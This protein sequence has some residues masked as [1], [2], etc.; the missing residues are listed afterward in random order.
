MAS[1]W[2]PEEE[3]I[4]GKHRLIEVE[5]LFPADLNNYL[6][7]ILSR[8]EHRARAAH[9]L[10][11]NLKFGFKSVPAAN[12][13]FL[14]LR[15]F[16][17]LEVADLE[18]IKCYI[19]TIINVLVQLGGVHE[20]PK[21]VQTTVNCLDSNAEN[22]VTCGIGGVGKSRGKNQGRTKEV[23]VEQHTIIDN[24]PPVHTHII[25]EWRVLYGPPSDNSFKRFSRVP[26]ENFKKLIPH[27]APSTPLHSLAL[28]MEHF[29]SQ[30]LNQEILPQEEARSSSSAAPITIPQHRTI[31]ILDSDEL[32]T[33][34]FLPPTVPLRRIKRTS[35]LCRYVSLLIHFFAA[36]IPIFRARYY[37][38]ASVMIRAPNLITNYRCLFYESAFERGLQFPMDDHLKELLASFNLTPV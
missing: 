4:K 5:Q 28:F 14:K 34:I 33:T 35:A 23:E 17:C 31:S 7:F 30:G 29:T 21:L 37:T 32:V 18:L 26:L 12:W 36:D 1:S 24:I 10:E 19:S 8:S 20:W 25:D 27:F 13:V 6:V 3:E 15:L 16:H 22:Q 11:E 2:K 38:P 9:L